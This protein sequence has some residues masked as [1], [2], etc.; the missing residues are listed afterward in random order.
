M[1]ALKDKFP[2]AGGEE[3]TALLLDDG[4]ALRASARRERVCDEA[5]EQNAAGEWRER[6]G[7]QFEQSGSDAGVGAKN[8][9]DFAGPRLKAGGFQSNEGG[10][11]R[12]RRIGV[13]DL[14]VTQAY[15]VGHAASL[16]KMPRVRGA[17][18]HAS[19]LRRR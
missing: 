13:T 5:V 10:L 4:D 1:A 9:H 12:I 18:A 11:R 8:G 6:T 2:G 19:L 17:G 3:Q 16:G 14:F 7:D 15:L